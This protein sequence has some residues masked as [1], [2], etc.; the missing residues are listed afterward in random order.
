MRPLLLFAP[1]IL[2]AAPHVEPVIPDFTP[3]AARFPDAAA[4]R[5]EIVRLL[6]AARAAGSDAAEGP[7][8]LESGDVRGHSVRAEGGGHRIAEHRCLDERLGSRSW[9]HSMGAPEQEF[10]IESVARSAPWLQ[11]P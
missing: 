2:A 11:H 1:L 7:Y 3:S 10:T 5:V 8:E 4:C 6:A 9:A